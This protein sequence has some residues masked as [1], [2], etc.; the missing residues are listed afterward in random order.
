MTFKTFKWGSLSIFPWTLS[1]WNLKISTILIGPLLPVILKIFPIWTMHSRKEKMF[2]DVLL[3]QACA[4][5]KPF[6]T[7]YH[8]TIKEWRNKI[9]ETFY[10]G[11][12][13]LHNLSEI[14]NISTKNFVLKLI[15]KPDMYS[16]ICQTWKME[17]FT[18]IING[19]KSLSIFE[20]CSIVD[21]WQDPGYG[22][23]NT[24]INWGYLNFRNW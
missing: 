24:N 18:K 1:N 7:N 8:K 20:K 5:N 2:P 16:E 13:C 6:I 12:K 14:K 17:C 21:V 10:E 22:F 19:W 4:R 3:F 11:S 23:R 9:L 15:R